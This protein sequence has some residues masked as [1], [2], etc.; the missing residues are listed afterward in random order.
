MQKPAF[1]SLL[2]LVLT[3]AAA[4]AAEKPAAPSID[5]KAYARYPRLT[6]DEVKALVR[7]LLAEED[8]AEAYEPS[9]TH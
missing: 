1:L 7:G 5:A 4:L 6:E 9:R 2:P 3:V 8:D